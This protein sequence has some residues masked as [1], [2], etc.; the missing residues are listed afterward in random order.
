MQLCMLLPASGVCC[1]RGLGFGVWPGVVLRSRCCSWFQPGSGIGRTQVAVTVSCAV[2]G[3][4]V[5][6]QCGKPGCSHRALYGVSL[7]A[8]ASC[9][10]VLGHVLDG[11]LQTYTEQP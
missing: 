5:Q 8:Y 2:A 6:S 9:A 4:G 11:A 3:I 10:G 7:V 1:L